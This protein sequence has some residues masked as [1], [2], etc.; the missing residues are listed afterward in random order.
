MVIV[1]EVGGT[2]PATGHRDE[3][4]TVEVGYGIGRG[5]QRYEDWENVW[6]RHRYAE[7]NPEFRFTAAER[8]PISR[9]VAEREGIPMWKRGQFQPGDEVAIY[10]GRY[11]AITGVILVRQTAYD[12]NSHGVQLQGVGV[13]WY[14]AHASILDKT[15]NYDGMTFKQVADKVLAPTGIKGLP[16]GKLNSIPFQR[17]QHEPGETVWDFLERIARVRGIILGSD[18]KGNML[19]I[20]WHKAEIEGELV[21]GINILKM[22]CIISVEHA[23]SKYL[24]RVQTAAND[25]NPGAKA[26]SMEATAEGNN[27]KRYFPLLV[28]VE[29]P[30]WNPAELK[31][32][33][34]NEKLWNEST[35]V[36]ATV[37]TQGWYR[38]DG[39]GIWRAGSVVRVYSPMAMINASLA[40]QTATFTQDSQSGTLTTLELVRP[41]RLKKF[42]DPYNQGKLPELTGQPQTNNAPPTTPPDA[43]VQEPPPETL[44]RGPR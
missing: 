26:A 21:E 20:D 1:T 40:I 19:L 35:I 15:G 30:V 6:V 10:L 41:E 38:P 17:L 37:T 36:T 18:N 11:L 23:R 27:A 24:A 12:A 9:E 22:Q 32:R 13:Q 25:S 28:P 8:D 16:V 42:G 3:I 4:A 44:P 31:D 14:A 34:E 33:V 5:R 29:Q 43:P 7:A 2:N 39:G